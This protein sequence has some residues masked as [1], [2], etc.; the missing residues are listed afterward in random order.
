MCDDEHFLMLNTAELLPNIRD[1]HHVGAYCHCFCHKIWPSST[2]F[3]TYCHLHLVITRALRCFA[4]LI[5]F[6]PTRYGYLT[7]AT[8]DVRTQQVVL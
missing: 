6:T 2:K 3:G 5:H 8:W 1:N 4:A 7:L